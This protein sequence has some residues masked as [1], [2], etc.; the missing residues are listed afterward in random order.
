M[1]R[2]LVVP[3]LLLA[4]HLFAAP[5]A[6]DAQALEVGRKVLRLNKALRASDDKELLAAVR[7]LGLDSRYYVMT[8][9][10]LTQELSSA[11]S[12]RDTSTYK[13]D[14]KRKNEI[15]A[16]IDLITRCLRAIDLE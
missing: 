9:G 15:D 14:A 1:K 12:Y 6:E 8:R 11:K 13:N 7:D 10:W 2:L 3:I 16:R 4:F 5:P